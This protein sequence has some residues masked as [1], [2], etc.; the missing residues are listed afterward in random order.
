MLERDT[1]TMKLQSDR[2]IQTQQLPL[3]F[4]NKTE[5]V[6]QLD[7]KL[8]YLGVDSLEP[9]KYLTSKRHDHVTDSLCLL[10]DHI[11][12]IYSYKR[13]TV[14]KVI[15]SYSL[16]IEKSTMAIVDWYIKL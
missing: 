4:S 2:K 5:V 16:Y 9:L 11:N 3:I 7:R 12:Y 10:S 15:L 8:F 1:H 14:M 13:T 6:F